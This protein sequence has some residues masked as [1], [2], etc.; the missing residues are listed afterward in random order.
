MSVRVSARGGP[1]R[2]RLLVRWVTDRCR[3]VRQ[4]PTGERAGAAGVTI[5]GVKEAQPAAA[6]AGRLRELTAAP[7]LFAGSGMSW[8][9]PGL[10]GREELLEDQCADF[11]R[12]HA[13]YRATA[14]ADLPG[15]ARL[16]SGRP[17]AAVVRSVRRPTSR[18]EPADTQWA[19]K[20]P[21]LRPRPA[22]WKPPI[23][24]SWSASPPS[25]TLA[26]TSSMSCGRGWRS[27]RMT[28]GRGAR[29]RPTCHM[30]VCPSDVLK[31]GPDSAHMGGA[32]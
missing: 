13:Y 31:H 7:F 6:F 21:P 32:G 22:S 12:P 25:S 14:G 11:L 23:W 17:G 10:A 4:P 16:S 29:T 26:R 18:Q 30:R 5:G 24:W 15:V 3:A 28:A 20:V 2:T 9:G 27:T 1:L 8:R 19:H